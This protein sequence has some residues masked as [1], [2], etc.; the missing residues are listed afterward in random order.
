MASDAP[1]AVEPKK[2]EYDTLNAV[3][4]MFSS[5]YS[6]EQMFGSANG[7]NRDFTTGTK[8]YPKSLHIYVNGV[9]KF[10]TR[11]Y[12]VIEDYK[13]RFNTA[14]SSLSIIYAEYV[15]PEQ[16]PNV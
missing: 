1:K 4:A 15:N 3:I 6:T 7:T 8:F 12:S 14:P 13:I 16:R 9:R 11:D 10:E 2:T 5:L